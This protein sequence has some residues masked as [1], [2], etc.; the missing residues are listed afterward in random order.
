MVIG[1]RWVIHGASITVGTMAGTTDGILGDTVLGLVIT[2]VG[3]D[4]IDGTIHEV[5]GT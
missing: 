5:D 4:G 2:M 3:T 1:M